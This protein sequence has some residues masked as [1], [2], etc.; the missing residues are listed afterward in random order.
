MKTQTK[1]LALFIL[2][3]S[4]FLPLDDVVTQ[5]NST[6]QSQPFQVGRL[7][8]IVFVGQ[9]SGW[10]VGYDGLNEKAVIIHTVNGGDLWELQE[11]PDFSNLNA[12]YMVDHNVGYAVGEDRFG[13]S[14][15]IVILKTTNGGQQWER[16]QIPEIEGKLH[17]VIFTSSDEGVVVGIGYD[18]VRTLIMRTTNGVDWEEV[19]HPFQRGALNA[20]HF[21]DNLHGWAAGR[22]ADPNAEMLPV[23]KTTDG[24]DTWTEVITPVSNGVFF[25][26]FF[27]TPDSGFIVGESDFNGVVLRTIDGGETWNETLFIPDQLPK[28]TSE[29]T[30]N[31]EITFNA[32][33]ISSIYLHNSVG[34]LTS[35]GYQGD[36][37]FF[38]L[39]FKTNDAGVNWMSYGANLSY[40][41][42]SKA[43]ISPVGDL[44]TTGFVSGDYPKYPYNP[45]IGKGV[46]PGKNELSAI[47]IDP[48]KVTLASGQTQKFIAKGEDPYRNPVDMR[49]PVF[50]LD[51]GGT[52]E[53]NGDECTFTAEEP[54]DWKLSC[55]DQGKLG[56]ASIEVVNPDFIFS[57]ID[58]HNVLHIRLG[59]NA[60]VKIGVDENGNVLVNGLVEGI[61]P[62]KAKD[63][64]GINVEGGDG[65]NVIDLRDVKREDFRNIEDGKIVLNG[66]A[67]D[68]VIYGS[69]IGD[70][71]DGGPGNDYLRG[72]DGNDVIYGGDGNDN[73]HGDGGNDR[74]MG[75]SGRNILNG[76]PGDD[77]LIGGPGDDLLIDEEGNNTFDGGAGND[78]LIS[79]PGSTNV[80]SDEAGDDTVDFSPA[81]FGITID[82]DLQDVDQ[83]VDTEGN[84]IRL[85][86]EFE[87]F[88]GSDFDDVVYLYPL[89]VPRRIDGGG[90]VQG[91]TIYID[92]KGLSVTQTDSTLT[93]EGYAPITY[94]NYASVNIIHRVLDRIEVTPAEI[95]LQLE[96]QQ[97]FTAAG[98]D[99]S[100][101]NMPVTLIWSTTGGSIDSSGL[102]TAT[103]AGE[104]T[105]TAS[106]DESSVIGIATVRVIRTSVERIGDMP[107]EFTLSQNYPNPFNPETIIEYSVKEACHVRLEIYNVVGRNVLTLVNSF[108]QPGVYRASFD[109]AG[110]ST[111]VYFYRI[112]M[113]DFVAVKKMVLLQ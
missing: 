79:K 61:P 106:T 84:I 98:F 44:F 97:Q 63:L 100:N 52:I 78:V 48:N 60:N 2:V 33:V 27:T 31:S 104:F 54:G 50:E 3:L 41:H 20:V 55:T 11:I 7:N 37:Y 89:A 17:D 24:G 40:A 65:D 111:G 103:E 1:H 83:V 53:Q 18:D 32:H 51:G 5:Q 9:D 77:E 58:E 93:V 82:L 47:G 95:T 12:I 66:N 46:A 68:D 4:F 72:G 6:F 15:K 39:F 38:S 109:A 62:F 25:D 67:G 21:P 85:E 10:A 64:K 75:G 71:I 86:G 22:A 87:N 107:K 99:G 74:L 91:D 8:D 69:Q 30:F 36:F 35:Q 13:G 28:S 108:Q 45:I 110:L 70:I 90:H 42:L 59:G 81:N 92:A 113:N 73:I 57:W 16:L 80:L 49:N 101:N 76:G 56:E 43:Y 88:T 26:V 14:W 105:V 94:Y 34:I 29:D 112:R 19:G 23:F 102:Y 96:E